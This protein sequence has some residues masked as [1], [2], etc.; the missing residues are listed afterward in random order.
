MRPACVLKVVLICSMCKGLF[1]MAMQVMQ[2]DHRRRLHSSVKLDMSRVE[3][4]AS[5]PGGQAL[6]ALSVTVTD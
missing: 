4:A 5:V 6:S 1:C 2:A 3:H